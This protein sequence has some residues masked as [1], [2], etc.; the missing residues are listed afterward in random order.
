VIRGCPVQASTIK[1]GRDLEMDGRTR[2]RLLEATGIWKFCAF[3]TIK[4]VSK[5]MI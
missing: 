2:T 5:E 3:D 4:I 1:L